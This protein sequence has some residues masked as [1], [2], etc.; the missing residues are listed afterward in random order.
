MNILFYYPDKERSISLSSLMIAFQKQGHTVHLLTHSTEGD[1]HQNVRKA[2]V[3]THTYPIPKNNSIIFFFKHI[4]FLISFTKKNNIAIVYSHIQVANFI[5]CISQ[6]FTPS[7]F[8]LCRHHSDCAYIDN[9]FNEKL[10]D[11]IINRLGKEFIVPSQKVY[12]QMVITE[13]VKNKKIYL[14]RYAYDFSQY[15]KP[16]NESVNAI[17]EEFKCKLLLIKTARLISEKRHIMLFKV[18]NQLAKKGLD[19]KLMVLSDGPERKNLEEY[20]AN[21]NLQNNI[22]MLGYRRDVI[23]YIAAADVV[24]HVSMSEASNS[25]VKEAGLLEKPVIAC[26]NVGDFDEYL[27]NNKNGIII[28]KENFENKLTKTLEQIYS[29]N[30]NISSLGNDL[31][32][33]I[34]DLFSI[35]SIIAKYNQFI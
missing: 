35:E 26:S 6:Y 10:L 29:G 31:K 3:V 7:R 9:N 8:I 15:A 21:N 33:T 12:D 20:I 16:V 1:L 34:L 4:L 22:F 27:S 2:G 5:S 30:Y 14:I 18:M 17:K 13:G 23:N 25:L 32:K 11:K 28:P 24:V 19:I